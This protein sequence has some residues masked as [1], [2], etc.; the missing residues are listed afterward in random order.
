M[1]AKNLAVLMQLKKAM[2]E[3]NPPAIPTPFDSTPEKPQ[4]TGWIVKNCR[5]CKTTKF[6]YRAEW[7]NPPVMCEG[8][9]NERKTRYKPGKGDT[10]MLKRKSFM[11]A[12]LA[13]DAESER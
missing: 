10:F 8:C 1:D 12:A 9:R 13:R 5:F 7:V 4:K 3:A 11:V 6:R 2:E